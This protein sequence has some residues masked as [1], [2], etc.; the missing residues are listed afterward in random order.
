MIAEPEYSHR[1]GSVSGGRARLTRSRCAIGH[2]KAHAPSSVFTLMPCCL[3]SRLLLPLLLG[4]GLGAN[5]ALAQSW[6]PR[7]PLPT[8]GVPRTHGAAVR[9]GGVLYLI[10]GTPFVGGDAAADAWDGNAWGPVAAAEGA[11]LHLGAAVDGLGRIVVFGGREPGGD[12]G[13]VYEWNA[14]DGNAGGLE[15]RSEQAPDML[16]AWATDDQGR[17]YSIGGG[18]GA[19]P[20]ASEPNVGHTERYEPATDSWTVL[21]PLPT[22]VADAAACNDGNGRILVFGGYD[23]SGVVTANVAAYHVATG[24]WS[25]LLVPDLPAPRAG[26]CAVL[27]ADGRVYVLGGTDGAIQPSTFIL[28]PGTNTWSVGPDMGTA[29]QHFGAVLDAAGEIWALGGETPS[30]GTNTAESLFTPTCPSIIT[31][32]SSASAWEGASF[33]LRLEVSGAAPF[34]YQW[35]KDGTPLLDGPTGTGS[36]VVGAQGQEFGVLNLGPSDAGT[37]HCEVANACGSTLSSS[38]V[39]SVA[40]P[41]TLPAGFA[42]DLLHPAGAT[43]S[44]AY[45]CDGGAVVGQF[46]Y[47]H[48]VHGTLSRPALWPAPGAA[49][50]DLTPQGSAGGGATAM[51]GGTIVGW[52]WWPYTTPQGTGYHKHAAVWTNGGSTHTDVQTSGWEIGSIAD[53]DGQHHA[54]G[55]RFDETATVSHGFHWPSTTALSPVNLTPTV[56]WGSSASAV[57]RGHQYGSVNL[58]YGVVHAARWSGSSG[59]FR[60]MTPASSGLSWVSGAGD[61]L[62]VGRATLSGSVT[63]GVWA[64]T[65]S[66]WMPLQQQGTLRDAEGGLLVGS[67]A[68]HAA[69]WRGPSAAP[70]DLHAFLPP[71]FTTSGAHGIEVATDGTISIAGYAHD[72]VLQRT[73]AIVWRGRAPRLLQSS[74][75][76]STSAG[77]SVTFTIDG[78]PA[79]AGALWFLGGSATGTSP[80]IPVGPGMVVPLV[81]DAYLDYLLSGTGWIA[82]TSGVLGGDGT[83]AATATLPPWAV[84]GFSL[85]LHHSF[86]ILSL[87]QTSIAATAPAVT[88]TLTP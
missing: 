12:R 87:D 2:D 74:S 13:E 34:S 29:R 5:D 59:T 51:A 22:P 38:A 58:G 80:G 76:L 20:A 73:E 75:Q 47:I 15:D 28:D 11:F 43:S 30:G 31:D 48:A 18:G 39:M 41:P 7:P 42:V 46:G 68:G 70:V 24:T 72:P 57:D 62:Q 82:P 69:L 1:E 50:V 63:Y 67:V 53:T 37:Y 8:G 26:A 77:G 64:D 83:A 86:A 10:G 81:P 9:D 4:F 79:L 66:S 16:F 19:T 85:P 3:A 40:A 14:V 45:G 49:V 33:G 65:S 23:A 17:I 25:D 55:Q 71:R 84:L 88:L 61:G 36:D 54:G 6:T 78:G 35:F 60:D 52:W 32:V 44:T 56:A 27:G 21:A